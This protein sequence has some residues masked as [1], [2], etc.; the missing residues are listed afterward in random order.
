MRI[1]IQVQDGGAEN[2]AR[3]ERDGGMAAGGVDAEESMYD[4]LMLWEEE[5]QEHLATRGCRDGRQGH[6]YGIGLRQRVADYLT[7]QYGAR[8]RFCFFLSFLSV[9]CRFLS[10][11]CP[12]PA[13]AWKIPLARWVFR[14]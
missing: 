12:A 7:R 11:M 5:R 14:V 2:G 4:V 10:H 9:S 8:F 6:Q 1:F 13:R 3:G